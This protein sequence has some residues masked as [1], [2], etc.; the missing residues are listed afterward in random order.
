MF[1][2]DRYVAALRFAAIKHEGQRMTGGELPYLV[3]VA[4]VASEVIAALEPGLDGDLAVQC[5]LLHDTLED[6]P[7]TFDELAA[8]FGRAVADGVLALSKIDDSIPK[9]DRM[10][11]SLR[12]I[13]LQPREVWIVKL[14]DRITN[15]APPPEQWSS[16]KRRAY[17]AEAVVIADALGTASPV[18]DARIRARIGAYA[19]YF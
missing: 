18:M 17:Q 11:D 12:R 9:D 19:R 3:H 1:T 15:L 6:T 16:E 2:V 4:S 14:G 13:R 10:A 7:T 5:A 8:E